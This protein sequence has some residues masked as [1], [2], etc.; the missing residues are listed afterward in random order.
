MSDMSDDGAGPLDGLRVIDVGVLVQGPQAAQ[1][2]YEM[3]ADV[4]K[5]E[6]P[7]IGDHARWIPI[8]ATDRRAPFLIGTNRGKRSIT[9]DLQNADG[10]QVFLDLAARADVVISNFAAGAMERCGVGYDDLAAVNPR[11]VYGAGTAYGLEGEAAGRKG[12]DL[13]AQAA[14]GLMRAIPA[15]DTAPGPVG[16]TIADHIAAQN[17]VNG[18]LAALLARER[19]GRGQKIETSLLGGQIYAQAS[20]YTATLLG[21]EELDPPTHGG[22]PLVPGVYGV[23][24]TADGAIALVGVTPPVRADFFATIGRPDLADDERFMARVVRPEDRDE[25]F[26]ALGAA[27]RTR[28]TAEWGALF[29]NSDIRWS[30]VRN[31]LDVAAD[32]DLHESGYFYTDHHPE[33]G[34][35]TMV[36]HPVRYSDTPARVGGLAPELGQHTEEILLELGRDWDDIAALREGGAL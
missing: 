21:G 20:E 12:A 24:P 13:G 11:L 31:R 4:V 6:V 9:L 17:M 34:E 2:L 29:G 15:G 1:M 28:T 18:I 27:M 36:G 33:W 7:G 30:P 14:G 8:S 19:T 26:T 10:R 25:L 5:V 3:G 23:V 16:I 22:H 32:P 35:V